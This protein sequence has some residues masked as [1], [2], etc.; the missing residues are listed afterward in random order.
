MKE[1]KITEED[2][3]DLLRY[4]RSRAY[5]SAM[6]LLKQLREIKQEEILKIIDS[7]GNKCRCGTCEECLIKKELKEKI[8]GK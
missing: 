3:D 1:F 7:C 8:V 2:R 6:G 5:G 4:I